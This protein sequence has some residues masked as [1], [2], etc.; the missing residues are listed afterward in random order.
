M[1]TS[2]LYDL[3]VWSVALGLWVILIT[4]A[5]LAGFDRFHQDTDR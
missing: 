3:A 2:T 5:V 1:N 4:V